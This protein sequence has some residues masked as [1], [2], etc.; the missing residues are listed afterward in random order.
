MREWPCDMQALCGGCGV[1]RQQYDTNMQLRCMWK[2]GMQRVKKTGQ[3]H[4][5]GKRRKEEGGCLC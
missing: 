4:R 1:T 3:V 2:G 5:G